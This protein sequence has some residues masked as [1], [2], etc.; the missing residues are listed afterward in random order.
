MRTTACEQKSDGEW[1]RSRSVGL[2]NGIW[3]NTMSRVLYGIRDSVHA[4]HA[5]E[6]RYISSSD[7]G[8]CRKSWWMSSNQKSFWNVRE[9]VVPV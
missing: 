6:M 8:I 4:S 5:L 2:R 7:T 9:K 1:N 3:L